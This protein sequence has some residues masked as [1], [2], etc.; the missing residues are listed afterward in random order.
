MVILALLR[1]FFSLGMIILPIL[2]IKWLRHLERQP[3]AFVESPHHGFFGHFHCFVN[4]TIVF[5]FLRT[6]VNAKVI[7]LSSLSQVFFFSSHTLEFFLP[8]E[9]PDWTDDENPKRFFYFV[10]ILESGSLH[11]VR[12]KALAV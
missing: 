7:F 4:F 12:K 8:F 5:I 6:D 1:L 2:I 10:E 3:L 11:T 9:T